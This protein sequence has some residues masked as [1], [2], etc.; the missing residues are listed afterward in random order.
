MHLVAE[1]PNV[2]FHDTLREVPTLSTKKRK[3][4]RGLL[5]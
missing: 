4:K 5:G 1:L 3:T 2:H